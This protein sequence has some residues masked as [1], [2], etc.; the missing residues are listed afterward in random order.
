[1]TILK[2]SFIYFLLLLSA[3][4]CVAQYNFSEASSYLKE[5]RSDLGGN[6][7]ALIWKDG[8]IIYQEQIGNMDTNKITP[9][10]SCSKW[11]T[12]ALVM[13]FVDEGKISLE[14]SIGK[15]LPIYSQYGKGQIKIKHCLSHTTG[16]ESEPLNLFTILHENSYSS[17]ES[18]VDDI[19]R[20]K[21]LIAAPGTEFRYSNIGLSIAARILEVI[22][23]K[24]FEELFQ[25]RI[26]IP[27]GMLNTSFGKSKLVS[28]SGGA[29]S[30]AN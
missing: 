15:F 10:A 23:N 29:R 4:I 5:H 16:I 19:A 2:K 26:A 9:I 30:T 11:L 6:V 25:E 28:P 22:S 27:L 17:L 12:A 3:N 14:D 7:A 13:T 1:M 18:Q 24:S 21:K 20:K 8:K